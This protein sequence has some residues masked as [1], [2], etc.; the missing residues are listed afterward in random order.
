MNVCLLVI[1]I[2]DADWISVIP[3]IYICVVPLGHPE[4]AQLVYNDSN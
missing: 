3:A 2:R 1:P 4:R